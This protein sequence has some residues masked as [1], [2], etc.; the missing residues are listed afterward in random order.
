MVKILLLAASIDLPMPLLMT[1]TV[2]LKISCQ[3]SVLRTSYL[4]LWVILISNI[5]NSHSHQPTNEF[6]NL[7]TS[8]SLYP[9]IS[10][11]TRITSSTATLIDNIFTNNLELNMNSGILYT[12]LSDHSPVSQVTH[13]K[14]IVEP[15]CQKRFVRLINSTTMSAFR[16]KLEGVDWSSVY[17]NNSANESY[18]TFSSLLTS[19]YSM[20]FPL[21]L[22]R[23]ACS[24]P[25]RPSKPWFSNGLFTSC[26]RKNSLYKQFQLNP[27]ALNK[28]RYIL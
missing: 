17:S 10:K 28:L 3:P 5:L 24:K 13:L 7:M 19:A 8:N 15:P 11:P 21:Q 9:L 25:L 14:M 2:L 6:I 12:G 4:I 27:P 18:D 22:P 1:T 26:K 23:P 16:F 20:S